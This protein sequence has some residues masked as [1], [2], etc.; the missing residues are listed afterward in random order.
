[1]RQS[2]QNF[3]IPPPGKPRAF[4]CTSCPGR[5][6]FERC[7]GGVGNLNRIYLSN[8]WVV[9]QKKTY[10]VIY[11]GAMRENVHVQAVRETHAKLLALTS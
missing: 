2:I 3:N 6:E 9:K 5:G 4:D 7:L 10:D 1:M 8:A 11:T